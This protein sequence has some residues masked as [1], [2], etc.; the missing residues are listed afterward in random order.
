MSEE[1]NC[2]S[3]KQSNEFNE[4]TE[5]KFDEL[6][7]NEILEFI[8]KN[9]DDRGRI[10]FGMKHLLSLKHQLLAYNIANNTSILSNVVKRLKSNPNLDEHEQF[11]ITMS[12]L[13]E[14]N[15]SNQPTLN[16]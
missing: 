4:I 5:L 14:A 2:T 13:L 1:K 8:D 9:K 6:I 10:K 7:L 11:K 15:S 3:L 12:N 16:E